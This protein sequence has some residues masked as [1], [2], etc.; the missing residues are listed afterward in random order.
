MLRQAQQPNQQLTV[1]EPSR[2]AASHPICHSE[3]VTKLWSLSLRSLSLSKCRSAEAQTIKQTPTVFKTLLELFYFIF[4]IFIMSL[5]ACHIEQS[6]NTRY[7]KK[8]FVT[9]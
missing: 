4:S 9:P 2:S 3:G 7:I 1:T 8:T 6:R 5:F